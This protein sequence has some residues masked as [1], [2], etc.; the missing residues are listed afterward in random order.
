MNPV[1][2]M[3]KAKKFFLVCLYFRVTLTKDP[4]NVN[5]PPAPLSTNDCP[6]TN[7]VALKFV[8]GTTPRRSGADGSPRAGL[9]DL[10]RP[11]P[12]LERSD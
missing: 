1:F 11:R 10:P 3:S 2:D 7:S 5:L 8:D 12:G 9:R 6:E 4:R